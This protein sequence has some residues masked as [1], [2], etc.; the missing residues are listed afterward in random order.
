MAFAACRRSAS[1]RPSRLGVNS[2]SSTA[3]ATRSRVASE[4]FACWCMTRE[5]VAMETP[6][7][8]AT[9]RIVG[10]TRFSPHAES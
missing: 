5:T 10:R 6:A 7:C 1:D 3:R 9:S 4:T 2:S 8:R